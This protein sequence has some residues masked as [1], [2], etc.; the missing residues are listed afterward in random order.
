[1]N[2]FLLTKRG[3]QFTLLSRSLIGS[4]TVICFARNSHFFIPAGANMRLVIGLALF[5]VSSSICFGQSESFEVVKLAEGVYA[6][7]RKEPPS[8]SSF[9][10]IWSSGPLLM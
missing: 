1:M 2:H 5:I 3:E 4:R 10:E 6:A 8:A 9:R 7:I